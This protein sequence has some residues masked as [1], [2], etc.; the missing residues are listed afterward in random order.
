MSTFVP[1]ERSCV[2]QYTTLLN[3]SVIE[4]LLA[5]HCLHD[6]KHKNTIACIRFLLINNHTVYCVSPY[7]AIFR[8]VK[9]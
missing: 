7:T 5:M 9:W 2:M 3:M 4:T 8:G 6:I 1:E